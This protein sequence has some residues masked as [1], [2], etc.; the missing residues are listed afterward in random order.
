MYLVYFLFDIS[1]N[2]A[3]R[4]VERYNGYIEK[5]EKKTQRKKDFLKKCLQ[6]VSDEAQE[7]ILYSVKQFRR[8]S[9][10]HFLS[11]SPKS[12]MDGIT[13]TTFQFKTTLLYVLFI[14]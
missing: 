11:F 6:N 12:K 3:K 8:K 10:K 7:T 1:S 14:H 13:T 9:A 2:F 4:T 5:D